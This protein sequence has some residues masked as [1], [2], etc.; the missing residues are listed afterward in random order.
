MSCKLLSFSPPSPVQLPVLSVL[1]WGQWLRLTACHRRGR[2]PKVRAN[3]F[4]AV[5]FRSRGLRMCDAFDWHPTHRRERGH[6]RG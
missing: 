5:F 3:L 4:S 1:L 2:P 6:I